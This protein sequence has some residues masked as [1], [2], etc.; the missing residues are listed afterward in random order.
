MAYLILI[1]NIQYLL[2]LM[3]F[4]YGLVTPTHVYGVS[5]LPQAFFVLKT[6]MPFFRKV[7]FCPKPLFLVMFDD[8]AYF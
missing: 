1:P 4:L 6:N 5:G 7:Y 3:T 2:I 8:Y